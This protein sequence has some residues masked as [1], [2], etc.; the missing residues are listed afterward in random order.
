[1]ARELLSLREIGRRLDVPPS[2]IVYYKDRFVRFIPT[3][4][5]KGRRLKYPPEAVTLF[6]E[7]REMF[8]RNLSAEEIESHLSEKDVI[9]GAYGPGVQTG[10]S[11][12]F[13]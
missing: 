12:F 5:G 9:A 7:I 11:G 2:S 4:G 3:A 8:E 10:A 1:M 13:L 6:K